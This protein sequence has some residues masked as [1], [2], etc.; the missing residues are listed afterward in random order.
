M[1]NNKNRY[2]KL[3]LTRDYGE[4]YM[5]FLF[6]NRYPPQKYQSIPKVVVNRSGWLMV[7]HF[8]KYYF[9]DFTDPGNSILEITKKEKGK[10]LFVGIPGDIPQ[11]WVVKR[12]NY[13]NGEVAFEIG[14]F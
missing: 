12:I 2:D 10:L 5:F 1:G 13:L 8:D 3:F 4:P 7:D 9:P 14:S 6:Y 11:D